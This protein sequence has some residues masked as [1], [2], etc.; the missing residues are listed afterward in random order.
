V[1]R[2]QAHTFGN[3]SERQARLLVPHAPA[4]DAYFDELVS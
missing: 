3:Q 4:A 2:G 1:P